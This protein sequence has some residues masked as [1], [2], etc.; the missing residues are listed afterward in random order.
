MHP[1]PRAETINPSVPSFLCS[2]FNLLVDRWFVAVTGPLVAA[3]VP[4]PAT[5]IIFSRS[6]FS[7]LNTFI[8]RK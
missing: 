7:R 6:I 1:N 5:L 2:I 8:K 4:D 3:A